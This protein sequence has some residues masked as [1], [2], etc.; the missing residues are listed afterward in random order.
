MRM[1]G[2]GAEE[3]Q[4]AEEDSDSGEDSDPYP[5]D[6]NGRYREFIGSLLGGW[7]QEEEARQGRP[8]L[9]R[10]ERKAAS[11]N[12]MEELEI[13]PQTSVSEL[14]EWATSIHRRDSKLQSFI[15]AKLR[16]R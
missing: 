4:R 7:I 16:P 12:I 6:D 1:A 13:D 11:R 2:R 3:S 8:P 5:E 15:D 9:S 10:P 14:H